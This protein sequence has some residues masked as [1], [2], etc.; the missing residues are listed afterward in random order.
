MAE[1]RRARPKKDDEAVKL[2]VLLNAV[3]KPGDRQQLEVTAEFSDGSRR[4]VTG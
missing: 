1:G 4:D 2:E 3:M